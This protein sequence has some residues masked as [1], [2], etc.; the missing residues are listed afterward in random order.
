MGKNGDKKGKKGDHNEAT[1]APA[2]TTATQPEEKK[3]GRKSLIESMTPSEIAKEIDELLATL[4]KSKDLDE[5]KRVRRALRL[6]G[7]RGGLNKNK[8]VEETV[9]GDEKTTATK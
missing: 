8:K 4:A 2:A 5:K 1:N 3:R 9:V 7:H 6:R